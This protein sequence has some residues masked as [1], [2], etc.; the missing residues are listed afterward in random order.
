MEDVIKAEYIRKCLCFPCYHKD[1]SDQF[2]REPYR[3]IVNNVKGYITCTDCGD[4]A[5]D[6]FVVV[7]EYTG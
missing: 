6:G 1:I 5:K 4:R 7:Y 2:I 3:K